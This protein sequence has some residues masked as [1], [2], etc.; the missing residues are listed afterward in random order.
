MKKRNYLIELNTW[1][2]A[3]SCTTRSQSITLNKSMVN[4]LSEV[5]DQ[6]MP[7]P[8]GMFV[9]KIAMEVARGGN[10][11]VYTRFKLLS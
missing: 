8:L 6:K 1:K 3:H 7:M 4:L 5:S 2:K 9:K 11:H 10:D